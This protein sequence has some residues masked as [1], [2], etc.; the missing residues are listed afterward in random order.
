MADEQIGVVARFAVKEA[1]IE[2][3]K[4]A[5]QRTMVE[6]T[7]GEPGC[8]RYEL[9]QDEAEP[10]R[11]AM[12]EEWESAEALETHL[13]LESLQAAVGALMP[14]GAEPISMQRFKQV[15]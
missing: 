1:D 15:S 2:A 8:I 6:P 12:V 5:A 3:F 13:A 4:D 10:W 9:W 11:F 14:M 7:Q